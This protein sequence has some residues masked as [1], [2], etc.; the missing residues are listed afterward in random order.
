MS[1]SNEA[2][3]YPRRVPLR[4]FLSKLALTTFKTL[5]DFQVEGQENIPATGPYLVVGNHFQ[6]C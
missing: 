1:P 3:H 6:P 2:F 5:A 4:K